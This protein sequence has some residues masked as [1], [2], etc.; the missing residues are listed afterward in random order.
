M[1]LKFA[2]MQSVLAFVVIY[3]VTHFLFRYPNEIALIYGGFA[4]LIMGALM[5]Y[6]SRDVVEH[7]AGVS[8][9]QA[10]D[11][12][13]A[14]LGG[15]QTPEPNGA[16]TVQTGFNYFWIAITCSPAKGGVDLRGSANHIRYVKHKLAGG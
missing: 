13:I 11:A 9:K 1:N 12:A 15:T 16:F 5:G 3:C 8:P 4:A 6:L 10:A 2:L 14:V 7:V